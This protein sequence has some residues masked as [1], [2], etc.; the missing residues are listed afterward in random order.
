VHDQGILVEST[1]PAPIDPVVVGDSMGLAGRLARGLDVVGLLTVELF[2]LPGGRIFINELA[3]R[4]HNSG[5]WTIEGA[6]TSQFEQH[7]RAICGLPL[8]APSPHGPTAMVNLLGSGE[9]RPARLVGLEDALRDAGAHVHV[10][11]KRRVFERRKMGHVT[12]IGHTPDEALERAHTAAHKL[13]W[14]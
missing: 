8:G 4:V 2:L 11:G 13:S 1:A 3:P 5:H 14:A 12:V 9:D 10:Y 6:V 7:V